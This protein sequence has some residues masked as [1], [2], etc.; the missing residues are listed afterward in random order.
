MM[1]V[2]VIYTIILFQVSYLIPPALPSEI[3]G[4]QLTS[5][6]H[7]FGEGFFD[8]SAIKTNEEIQIDANWVRAN[9]G[10]GLSYNFESI[11]DRSRIQRIHVEVKNEKGSKSIIEAGFSASHELKCCSQSEENLVITEEWQAWEFDTTH[12]KRT[13]SDRKL[14]FESFLI[15]SPMVTLFFLKP[16]NE[17]IQKDTIKVRNLYIIFDDGETLF[18][19]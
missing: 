3:L 2:L 9:W 6:W 17:E 14:P 12:L 11:G 7:V 19:N 15:D 13:E 5:S 10:L 18:Y 8:G 16:K 4:P 1:K